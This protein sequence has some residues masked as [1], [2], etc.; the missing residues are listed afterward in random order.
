MRH[1]FLILIVQPET[2]FNIWLALKFSLK[3]GDSFQLCQTG[4]NVRATPFH[5]RFFWNFHQFIWSRLSYV[6][7]LQHVSYITLI[8]QPTLNFFFNEI[9]VYIILSH[10]YF[11]IYYDWRI[12]KKAANSNILFCPYVNGISNLPTKV[13]CS[14]VV[15]SKA[16]NVMNHS[17][18]FN[19]WE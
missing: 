10:Y 18:I 11:L 6:I 9:N 19:I 4:G 14:R 1:N 2:L 12:Y 13:Y 8:S 3:H 15:T 17:W 16:F 5:A 7:W